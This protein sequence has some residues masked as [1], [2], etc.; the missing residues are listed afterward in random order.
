MHELSESKRIAFYKA[1]EGREAKVL[2][3]STVRDGFR[4]G[5]TENYI[6]VEVPATADEVNT[7]VPVR[8]VRLAPDGLSISSRRT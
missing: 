3:E 1:H 8:L 7:I 6:R 2:V 4:I 5:F